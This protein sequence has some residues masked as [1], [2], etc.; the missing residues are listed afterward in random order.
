MT[1]E[2][3]LADAPLSVVNFVGG[4]NRPGIAVLMIVIVLAGIFMIT[5]LLVPVPLSDVLSLE[6]LLFSCLSF[7]WIILAVIVALL[8]Y[9]RIEANETGLT[10]QRGLICRHISWDQA[11]LFAVDH[12]KNNKKEE[13]ASNW[14]ELSGKRRVVRWDY[15]AEIS[16]RTLL[17]FT[18][19]EYRQ[20]LER[21]RSYI[22]EK[23]A[24]PLRDL[25]SFRK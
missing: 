20:A 14:D 24:L 23:T 25:R 18:P 16:P 17:Q 7:S 19:P 21:L 9:Q 1:G 11:Q 12:R 3:D 15:D 22:H 6:T 8:L 13:G 4:P 2:L 5:T 10:V